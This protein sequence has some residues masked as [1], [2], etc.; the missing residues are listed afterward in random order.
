M[1]KTEGVH[2][3]YDA[4]NAFAFPDIRCD[5]KES[6]L[7]LGNSGVGKSTL[8]HLLAGLMQPTSGSIIIDDQDITEL[9][10]AA[11][12]RFRGDNIGII[13]QKNHF[14]EALSVI[15]N[16]TLAQYLAG[17]NQDKSACQNLLDRLNIGRKAHQNIKTLSQGE[18]QRVAIAR[19]LVNGPQVIF[20]DE[21]TSALDDENCQSVI[22]L[23]QEQA[24]IAEA[25]LVIVTHDNRLKDIMNN[26]V[27]L[28]VA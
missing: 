21:P 23:L 1:L 12:D 24:A 5:R 26:Q 11:M 27:K 17:A 15:E 16:L 20:A 9:S 13:F 4:T 19:A 6:L 8:L 14:V 7:I 18:M 22:E 3:R 28:E 25:A 10:G 2:F